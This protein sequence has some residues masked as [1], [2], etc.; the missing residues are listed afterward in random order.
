M[1]FECSPLLSISFYTAFQFAMA[2]VYITSFNSSS[3]PPQVAIIVTLVFQME[4]W[5]ER[6][7]RL[8]VEG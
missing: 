3:K 1:N 4:E 7:E 8:C 2:F 6:S 5:G